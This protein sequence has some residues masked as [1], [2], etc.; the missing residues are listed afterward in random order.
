MAFPAPDPRLLS[1]AAQVDALPVLLAPLGQLS[2]DGQLRELIEE[3]RGRHEGTGPIWYLQPD[4][5][6]TLGLDQACTQEAV[7]TTSA[8]VLTWLRLRFGGRT[9][10][11][12][13]S[14][15]WLDAEAKALP[16][17][18]RLATLV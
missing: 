8:P 5:V 1:G 2:A 7:V 10:L 15:A 14:Q 4:Q 3:R 16:P 17:G 9:S 13:V 18:P 12:P 11:A 6:A